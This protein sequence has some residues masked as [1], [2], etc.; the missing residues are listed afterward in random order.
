MSKYHNIK[1][2]LD[3]HI[4]DSKKEAGRYQQ[5]K[6]L[7]KAGEIMDLKLQVKMPFFMNGEKVFN[8]IADFAYFD[9][10]KKKLVIE[11]VKSE[12]T[13]KLPLYRLKKKIIEA[14]YNVTITEV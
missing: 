11:D 8:Y 3:G 12:V 13:K 2:E 4:F 7:V 1:T 10:K 14:K 9:I 6:L 5:L